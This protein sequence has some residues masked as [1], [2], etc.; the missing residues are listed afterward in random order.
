MD[1]RFPTQNGGLNAVEGSARYPLQ[2][3]FCPLHPLPGAEGAVDGCAEG[4]RWRDPNAPTLECALGAS[5]APPSEPHQSRRYFAL[6]FLLSV[7]HGRYFVWGFGVRECR[8]LL[9]QVMGERQGL[10]FAFVPHVF[11]Q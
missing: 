3:R 7:K 9:V 8:A 11:R 10:S 5:G 6:E 1:W 2:M 4:L